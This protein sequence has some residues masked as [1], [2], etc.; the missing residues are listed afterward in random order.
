M[1]N[2]KYYYQLLISSNDL[3]LV[4]LFSFRKFFIQDTGGTRIQIIQLI[5]ITNSLFKSL[6]LLFSSYLKSKY[7][8]SKE[9]LYF[10]CTLKFSLFKL[11][12]KLSNHNPNHNLSHNLSHNPSLNLNFQLPQRLQLL[13]LLYK[14]FPLL[15]LNK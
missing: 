7:L 14:L 12:L 10:L 8:L 15:Q 5:Y 4:N 6:V 3:I 2:Y 13:L 11:N 9:M 1:F